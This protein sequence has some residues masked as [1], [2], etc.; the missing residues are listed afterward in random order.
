MTNPLD[1]QKVPEEG[2]PQR[3]GGARCVS[4]CSCTQ[5]NG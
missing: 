1:L 3:N 2:A 4:V 5:V